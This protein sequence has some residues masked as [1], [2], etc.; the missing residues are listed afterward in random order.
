MNIIIRAW[1]GGFSPEEAD[2]FNNKYT[3]VDVIKEL[4]ELK[5]KYGGNCRVVTMHEDRRYGEDHEFRY[6]YGSIG[7]KD[8]YAEK[9]EDD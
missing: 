6:V 3:I 4:N 5:S 7:K 9:G 2:F 8:I 1:N